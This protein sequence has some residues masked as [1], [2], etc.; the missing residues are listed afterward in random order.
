VI[1]VINLKGGV[2]KTTLS[3]NLGATLA[4]SGEAVLAIDLDYQHSLSDLCFPE[5]RRDELLAHNCLI[6]RLFEAGG[7]TTSLLPQWTA[8]VGDSSL[9]AVVA[10]EG[11][12][13]AEERVRAAWLLGKSGVDARYLLRAA[14]HETSVRD[15]FDWV[16]LDCPPR[17][18][19]A[20][21]NA[22]CAADY[23]LIPTILDAVSSNAVPR[24]LQWLQRLKGTER[25]CPQLE[26]LGVV[27][28]KTHQLRQMTALE[29]TRWDSLQGQCAPK[30]PM[31]IHFF[32]QFIPSKVDF[33]RAA[34]EARFA[35]D[36]SSDIRAR[37]MDLAEEIRSR[38]PLLC[39]SAI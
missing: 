30:W 1:A 19:T 5:Q 20:A 3:A 36:Q 18:T 21:I 26:L 16:V 38:V 9:H 33:A 6:D 14:I 22:L 31:P 2:G 13:T 28:N 39:K 4:A 12:Q 32:E 29:A 11:L 7:R 34:A 17:L 35:I 8:R 10:D 25:L 15:A 27:A 37:F 23:V 24:M